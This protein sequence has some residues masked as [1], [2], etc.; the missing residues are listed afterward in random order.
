MNFANVP[1]AGAC[2]AGN[3]ARLRFLFTIPHLALLS[4]YDFVSD[5]IDLHAYYVIVVAAHMVC[6]P[7]KLSA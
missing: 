3:V 4:R 1:M 6:S 7:H 5:H 2:F